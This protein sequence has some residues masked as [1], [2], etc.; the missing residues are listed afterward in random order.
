MHYHS[1]KNTIFK[2]K[3]L[4][5]FFPSMIS[6][7]TN[8]SRVNFITTV[9]KIKK[10][11]KF[12]LHVNQNSVNYCYRIECQYF[13]PKKCRIIMSTQ[14]VEVEETAVDVYWICAYHIWQDCAQY[15]LHVTSPSFSFHGRINSALNFKGNHW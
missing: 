11:Q 14:T 7:W 1:G 15:F 9:W 5:C 2:P 13:K 12:W 10:T 6:N 4:G 8:D 3:V